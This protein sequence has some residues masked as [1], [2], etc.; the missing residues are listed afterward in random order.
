M[1]KIKPCQY[2]GEVPDVEEFTACDGCDVAAYAL[3]CKNPRGRGCRSKDINSFT[4]DL[5]QI[6]TE[7]D[8]INMWNSGE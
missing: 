5:D 4:C 1:D 3:Q 7:E 8:A 6:S 2:C